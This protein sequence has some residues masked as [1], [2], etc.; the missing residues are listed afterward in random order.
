MVLAALVGLVLGA[1]ATT[2]LKETFDRECLQLMYTC[3]V[4]IY[5]HPPD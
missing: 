5:Q 1:S 3:R 4:C 2:Y